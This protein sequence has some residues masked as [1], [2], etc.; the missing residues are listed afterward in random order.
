MTDLEKQWEKTAT[1][2]VLVVGRNRTGVL[3]QTSNLQWMQLPTAA[4]S[5]WMKL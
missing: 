1:V 4:S 3:W 5:T 2:G